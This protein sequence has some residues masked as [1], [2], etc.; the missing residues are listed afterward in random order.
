MDP[1]SGVASILAIA[2]AANVVLRSIERIRTSVRAPEAIEALV[3][4]VQALRAL[5]SDA[6]EVQGLLKQV[7]LLLNS[8]EVVDPAKVTRNSAIAF[9]LV[10]AGRKL[11]E[12]DEVINKKLIKGSWKGTSRSKRIR[13][14]WLRY[15][16]HVE[17]L[18]TE[19]RSINNGL[20]TC[21]TTMAISGQ[22]QLQI[23]VQEVAQA[24]DKISGDRTQLNNAICSRLSVQ[25][26]QLLQLSKQI[27]QLQKSNEN[28][29]STAKRVEESRG[30]LILGKEK[31]DNTDIA[32][33]TACGL[34]GAVK[35]K[36]SIN[37]LVRYSTS[38]KCC[39]YPRRRVQIS[40]ALSFLIGSVCIS[41][42]GGQISQPCEQSL[43]RTKLPIRLN[44][45]Y[46]FPRWFLAMVVNI[47][48]SFDP[49]GSPSVSLQ[50]PRI[51]P[52][53]SKIFHLATAGDIEGMKSMFERG[54][55]SP[56]DVSYTFG[57]SVLHVS[58][59]HNN[60]TA[61]H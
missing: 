26:D 41:Y 15:Q 42:L 55:A 47:F 21:L 16:S 46:Y 28:Q 2:G 37:N 40:N 31:T 24:T 45:N 4:E 13:L 3:H 32:R 22:V 53:T 5:L 34:E 52:D 6:G 43:C 36:T 49:A 17:V 20:T 14:Q 19:L 33:Y 10:Q 18:Q 59:C 30:G 56:N 58:V 57:Y 61:I 38:S 7:S 8:L 54:L 51:R 29:Q 39:C 60:T 12:L 11:D 27:S 23:S 44:I 48:L 35:V 25:E 1:L 9:Y 50:I